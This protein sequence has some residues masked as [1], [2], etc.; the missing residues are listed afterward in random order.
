MHRYDIIR[1]LNVSATNML[2]PSSVTKCDDILPNEIVR[3]MGLTSDQDYIRIEQ[4]IGDIS[5]RWS[6][7]KTAFETADRQYRGKCH[8]NYYSVKL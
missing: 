6:T 3:S 2:L 1:P 8:V 4:T 7:A 5:R